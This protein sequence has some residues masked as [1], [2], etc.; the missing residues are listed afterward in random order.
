M[1]SQSARG[2]FAKSFWSLYPLAFAAVALGVL[3][4]H[5]L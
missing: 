1:V 3:F 4:G 2:T 5:W